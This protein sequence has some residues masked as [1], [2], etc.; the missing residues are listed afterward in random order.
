M[1]IGDIQDILRFHKKLNRNAPRSFDLQGFEAGNNTLSRFY[2]AILQAKSGSTDHSIYSA[3]YGDGLPDEKYHFLK[4][5]FTSI[6]LDQFLRRHIA[7]RIDSKLAKGVYGA[8]KLYIVATLLNKL[9]SKNAAKT[10]ATKALRHCERFQ[11]RTL[12]I[13][14]LEDLRHYA[15]ID[16]KTLQYKRYTKEIDDIVELLRAELEMKNLDQRIRVQLAKTL[17]IPNALRS[18]LTESLVRAEQLATTYENSY[19]IQLAHYRIAYMCHQAMG[20]Y[21]KSIDSSRGA[22]L[23]ISSQ[24]HF[25]SKARMGEYALYILENHLLIHEHSGV[26]SAIKLCSQYIVPG[27]NLWFKYKEYHFLFTMHADEVHLASAIMKEIFSHDRY[28]LQIEHLKERWSIY[29]LSLEYRLWVDQKTRATVGKPVI[30]LLRYKKYRQRL[31]SYPTYT[32]DKEGLNIAVLVLNILLLLESGHDAEIIEQMEALSTY[33]YK[34]LKGESQTAILF[35]L[36][37]MLIQY[38][39]SYD[40]VLKKTEKWKKRMESLSKKAFEIT[41][42]I[43]VLPPLWIWNRVMAILEL[44]SK[45]RKAK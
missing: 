40:A 34:Y 20:N 19:A 38:N 45:R 27:S 1:H 18:I 3:V 44:R 22:L 33:R 5:Y 29:Q 6:L 32:K 13:D 23:Y 14:L 9:G 15:V 35:R 25:Y 26:K 11:L 10:L 16:G 42:A 24:T 43:Q 31:R 12:S 30:P 37:T 7:K 36:F 39:F 4:S 28:E 17:S 21:E 2:K 41:E 8:Q